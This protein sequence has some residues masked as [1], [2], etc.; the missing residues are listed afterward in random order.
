MSKNMLIKDLY[1][2]FEIYRIKKNEWSFSCR[3]G[4][5]PEIFKTKNEA[6]KYVLKIMGK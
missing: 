4:I 2:E 6:I 1:L 3:Q 5:R